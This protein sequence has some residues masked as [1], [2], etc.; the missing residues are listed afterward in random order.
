M[1]SNSIISLSNISDND[2]ERVRK[3]NGFENRDQLYSAIGTGQKDPALILH[4]LRS[5]ST[6]SRKAEEVTK[7]PV[8]N[9]GNKLFK[10]APCCTP[11]PMDDEIIGHY[12]KATNTMHIHRK[13]CTHTQRG[14]RVDPENWTPLQWDPEQQG[15]YS[16]RLDIEVTEAHATLELITKQIALKSSSITGF[17]LRPVTAEFGYLLTIVKDSKHLQK[18]INDIREIETVRLVSRHLESDHKD[19]AGRR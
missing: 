12:I 5:V 19:E 9:L 18:I 6:T 10:L 17:S 4:L 14:F 11:V 3:S 7:A 13:D 1:Q 16:V 2:W 15:V 8:L